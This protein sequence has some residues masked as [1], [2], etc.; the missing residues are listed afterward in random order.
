MAGRCHW[1]VA[2][3]MIVRQRILGIVE[4]T[5]EDGSACAGIILDPKL[6]PV[7]ARLMRPFQGWRYLNI[8]DAPADLRDTPAAR[9]ESGLPPALR[10]E[11]RS[12]CLL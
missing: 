10:R 2:G 1:V 12:L 4:D 9:G 3:A 5:L 7:S 11:L 8:E 6:V